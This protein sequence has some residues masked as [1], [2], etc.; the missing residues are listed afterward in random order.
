MGLF[1]KKQAPIVDPVCGMT[2]E[3]KGAFGSATHA[4]KTYYFCSASCLES[5]KR[6][7]GRY[8]R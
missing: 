3:P 6:E 5:F 7:P 4:G 8:A 2:V 1:G